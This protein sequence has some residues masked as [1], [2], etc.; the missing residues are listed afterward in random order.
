MIDRFIQIT[1]AVIEEDGF[2]GYL[3]TLLLPQQNEYWYSMTFRTRSTSGRPRSTG[4]A[5]LRDR[6]RIIFWRLN[7]TTAIS[8]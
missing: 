4:P 1:R 7:S 2:D 8:K 3:P 5:P 6:S